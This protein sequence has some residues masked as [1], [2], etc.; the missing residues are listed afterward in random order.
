VQEALLEHIACPECGGDL[1]LESPS[2]ETDIET[3][4]LTCAGCGASYEIR[5]G[6]PRLL[7]QNVSPLQRR[8][9]NAF[10]WQWQHFVEMHAL[11]EEQ[12]L[13]WIEPL[14]PQDFEGRLVLDAG[15]GM[16][17]HAF[18]A[19]R[20]GARTV[21]AMD[22]SDAVETARDVLRDLPNAHVV[23]GD[24]HRP[25][26]RRRDR[27]GE[28]DLIYSIGVIHHLPV[29]RRGFN[30]LLP[31]LR[32]GGTLAI[33]VYGYENNGFVRHVIEPF[34]QKVTTRLRPGTLQTIAWPL[35]VLFHAVVKGIYG[36]T[37]GKRIAA[38]LPMAAYLSSLADFTFR[39]SHN[40]VF[41]QLVAPSAEYLRKDEVRSWFKDAGL[42]A[43][44]LSHRHGN[45]W[46]ARGRRPMKP[47]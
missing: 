13:D 5:A 2:A 33:W 45:S 27:E 21:I 19:A 16:G 4:R 38:A 37:R 15:C 28:F 1:H 3:G 46:R 10:G 34:R 31:F 44:H 11:F 41:D 43:I 8:T 42:E 47:N 6:I 35:A 17:R 32:R 29:P 36:P 23:Q 40:I 22:I 14:G 39:Q 24:I 12:F 18:Y 9:A 20:Y 26:F 30:A 25:P 7:P